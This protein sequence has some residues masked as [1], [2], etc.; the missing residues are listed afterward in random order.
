M[1]LGDRASDFLRMFDFSIDMDAT[2]A[3]HEDAF[4]EFKE[5]M[6]IHMERY[7][8]L[9][10]GSEKKW[11]PLDFLRHTYRHDKNFRFHLVRFTKGLTERD[12]KEVDEEAVE[13]IGVGHIGT[14]FLTW[15][16]VLAL[17]VLEGVDKS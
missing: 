15:D 5:Y 10:E 1:G 14:Q 3:L 2:S 11:L 13:E 4:K 7:S 12:H 16:M 8:V 17:M 9:F 6:D